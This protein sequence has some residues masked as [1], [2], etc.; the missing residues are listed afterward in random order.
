[1]S[2]IKFADGLSFFK[3]HANAPDF[4]LGKISIDPKKLV[5]WLRAEYKN[6]EI[7]GYLNLSVKMSKAGKPYV[8]LDTYKPKT[9]EK[10]DFT[11]VDEEF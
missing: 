5:P 2:D 4:V 6:N 9:E 1:M 11:H 3:P 8:C 10:P 7:N